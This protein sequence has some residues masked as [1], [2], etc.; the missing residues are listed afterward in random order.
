VRVEL[1]RARLTIEAAKAALTA[2]DEALTNAR[3]RLGLAE[4]RYE[5]GV[6]NAIELGD[7]QLALTDAAAQRVQMEYNL[8]IAR[9]QLLA[10]LGKSP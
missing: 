3:A 9:A 5:A 2:S 7:A 6:G 1:E 4:G 8:A 10:A